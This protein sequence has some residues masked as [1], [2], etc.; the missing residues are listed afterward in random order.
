MSSMQILNKKTV[1]PHGLVFMILALA[2][3][4]ICGLFKLTS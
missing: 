4:Y 2:M 3:A 1:V